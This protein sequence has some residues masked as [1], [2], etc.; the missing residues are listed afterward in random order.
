MARHILSHIP[1]G[2]GCAPAALAKALDT[3]GIEVKEPA[4]ASF[5]EEGAAAGLLVRSKNPRG[6]ALYGV[7]DAAGAPSTPPETLTVKPQQGGVQVDLE[8]SSLLAILAAA[9]LSCAS[10]KDGQLVLEP[11]LVRMGRVD[12]AQSEVVRSLRSASPAFDAAAKTV[13]ERRGQ[14]IVHRG[15]TVLR[16]EDVGLRALILR[17]FGSAVRELDGGY[18]AVLSSHLDEIL[19]LTKREG[20]AARRLP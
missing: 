2:Q 1:K 6:T 7:P 5:C 19:A 8:K 20:F 17:K 15:L 11:D 9:A 12:L 4:V 10:V 13:L 14:V 18:V 3:L 16:V